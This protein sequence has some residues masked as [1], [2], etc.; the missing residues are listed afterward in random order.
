MV[1]KLGVVAEQQRGSFG[2]NWQQR[3]EDF[4][5]NLL[6]PLGI[7]AARVY[8]QGPLVTLDVPGEPPVSAPDADA[9]LYQSTGVALPVAPL[10]YWVRGKPAP[11]RF[12]RTRTGFIQAGWTVEYLG[13]EQGLPTRM[14]VE[15]PEVRLMLVVRAW[16]A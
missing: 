2:I 3:G 13:F 4:E 15:R 10:R 8:R 12:A 14:R 11:G 9:L 7:S 1:G 16:E 5:I 6:G